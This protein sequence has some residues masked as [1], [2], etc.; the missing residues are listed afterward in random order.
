ML[1]LATSI[2]YWQVPYLK[3][4][5]PIWIKWM[6]NKLNWIELKKGNDFNILNLVTVIYKNGCCVHLRLLTSVEKNFPGDHYLNV[7]VCNGTAALIFWKQGSYNWMNVNAA[8]T[9][10][11][12]IISEVYVNANNFFFYMFKL[13]GNLLNFYVMLHDLCF[14]FHKM[15]YI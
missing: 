2:L 12:I 5:L 8:F 1:I 7:M 6:L 14:I 10:C 13:Q 3:G 11:D 9:K 4:L 15:P